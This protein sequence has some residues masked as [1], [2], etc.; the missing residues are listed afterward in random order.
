MWSMSVAATVTALQEGTEGKVTE[1]SAISNSLGAY[2]MR[3][4]YGAALC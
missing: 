4:P 2:K 3:Q 1:A